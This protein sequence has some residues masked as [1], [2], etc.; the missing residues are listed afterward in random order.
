MLLISEKVKPISEN[1]HKHYT[2][3]SRRRRP[4]EMKAAS[5]RPAGMELE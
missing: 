4:D 5:M 1:Q 2:F 3:S